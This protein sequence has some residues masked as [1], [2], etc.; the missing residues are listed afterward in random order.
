MEGG[1]EPQLN[2]EQCWLNPMKKAHANE[3]TTTP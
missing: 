2:K 3:T 1:E